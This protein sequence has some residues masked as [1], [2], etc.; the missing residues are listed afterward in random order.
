MSNPSDAQP[1]PATS[2]P[3]LH[4]GFRDPRRVA[5]DELVWFLCEADRLPGIRAIQKAMRRCFDL[6]PGT[7][8]LDAG[9]GIGLEA[10]RLASEHPAVSVTGLD[11]NAELLRVARRDRDPQPANL[12]WLEADLVELD[13]PD[14]CFDIVR[15]ERVL[16]YLPDPELDRVV[17]ELVRLLRP[18]GRLVLFELDYGAAILP[19][20]SHGDAVVRRVNE[21]L[22]DSVPQPRAGRRIPAMLSDRGLIDTDAQPFSFA[23]NEPIWLRIVHDTLTASARGGETLDPSVRSWLD[24]Q[25]EA[26][27]RGAFLG[28]FT[29]ILTTARN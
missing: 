3:D 23:V 16:M 20:G 15:T 9:C 25:S 10:A 22:D 4:E 13:L 24:E 26:A 18:G 11:R 14:A 19:A 5:A 8:L 6:R 2:S 28:A 1:R 29:G 27:A 7:H 21:L 12:S 17:D